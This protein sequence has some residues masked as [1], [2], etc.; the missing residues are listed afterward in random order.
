VECTELRVLE[1]IGRLHERRRRGA[2]EKQRELL[3]ACRAFEPVARDDGQLERQRCFF[4][5]P[6][7]EHAAFERLETFFG[8]LVEH[9]SSG[10]GALRSNVARPLYSRATVAIATR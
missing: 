3:A 5:E 2:A 6:H 7:R 4:T 1:S 8:Q 9:V 10:Q